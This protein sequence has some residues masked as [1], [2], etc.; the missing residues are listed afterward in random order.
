MR[1][2]LLLYFKQK[3]EIITDLFMN[4]FFFFLPI[5]SQC[6]FLP[7]P[8]SVGLVI[9]FHYRACDAPFEMV[10]VKDWIFFSLFFY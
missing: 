8:K 1:F 3:N 10:S 5:S 2:L 9:F 6:V 7:K 4:F